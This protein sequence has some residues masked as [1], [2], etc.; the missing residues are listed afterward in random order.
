MCDGRKLER[1][2]S[3][4]KRITVVIAAYYEAANIEDLPHERLE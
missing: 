1:R 3:G 2:K 4:R